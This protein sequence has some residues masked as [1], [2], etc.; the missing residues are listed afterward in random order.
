MLQ[1]NQRLEIKKIGEM[2]EKIINWKTF[3]KENQFP[4]LLNSIAKDLLLTFGRKRTALLGCA[5]IL[6]ATDLMQESENLEA[7]KTITKYQQ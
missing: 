5:L 2:L 3:E 6:L 1:E 4:K 7:I